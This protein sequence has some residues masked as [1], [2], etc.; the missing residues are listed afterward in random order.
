M[1]LSAEGL[2]VGTMLHAEPF[3]LIAIVRVRK[4]EVGSL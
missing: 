2:A 1:L 3:H 4:G